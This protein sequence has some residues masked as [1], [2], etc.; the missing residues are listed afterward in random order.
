MTALISSFPRYILALCL[1]AAAG[2]S[3]TLCLAGWA[4]VAPFMWVTYSS[5]FGCRYFFLCA[6]R[7][8]DQ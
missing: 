2:D 7:I 3:S 4:S 6:I 1:H 5:I 8:Y